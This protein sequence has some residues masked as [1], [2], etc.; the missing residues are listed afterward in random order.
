MI[1]KRE[2][3][4]EAVTALRVSDAEQLAREGDDRD[5]EAAR[6]DGAAA[7]RDRAAEGRD[8]EWASRNGSLQGAAALER[9]LTEVKMIRAQAAA[10]R[11]SAEDDRRLAARDRERASR[12]RADLLEALRRAHFDD[13]TGAHRRSF[14]EQALRAEIERARRSDG[15]L[16]LG[17]VDVDGLKEVN[18]SDG[19]LAGDRLLCD[20]VEAIRSNIR[21]YEPVIRLGGD[22]FA[23]AMSGSDGEGMRERCAVIKADLG[24]RPAGGTITI[25][26]AELRP[27]DDLSDLFHRADAALLR[28]RAER[29]GSYHA[30]R[31]Q[32][33]V[34]QI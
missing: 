24:R 21:S 11:D 2:P 23:F 19:H 9:L 30:L 15:R 6:R 27:E 1:R 12:E 26:V 28:A 3:D 13:L 17:F 29:G 16:A 25:G 34:D 8:R 31:R 7:A 4:G 33:T 18:D 14:G 20:V 22:E 5:R 32:A 10:D